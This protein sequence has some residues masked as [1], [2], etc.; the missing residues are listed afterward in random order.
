M[1]VGWP[2][3]EAADR[4]SGPPHAF[5]ARANRTLP[6]RCNL[7]LAYHC[8]LA[9]FA[10]LLLLDGS[11]DANGG[12]S[13][14]GASGSGTRQGSSSSVTQRPPH[15][16]ATLGEVI[17]S[18]PGG[19]ALAR[20]AAATWPPTYAHAD[21]DTFIELV[22]VGCKGWE[23]QAAFSPPLTIDQVNYL[24]RKHRLQGV[25]VAA[26][27][28]ALPCFE[29]L[30]EAWQHDS[31]AFVQRMAEAHGVNA[32]TLRRHCTAIGFELG[33]PATDPEVLD[34]LA[35]LRQQ[36]WCASLGVTFADARLRSLGIHARPDVIRRCLKTIDPLGAVA[37]AK[38]LAKTKYR[39]SVPG[40][41]SLYHMDAHE[42][43][44]KLW[45][46]WLHLMVDGYSRRILY[47]GARDNK[48]ARTVQSCFLTFCEAPCELTGAPHRWSSRVRMDKGRE[49]VLVALSQVERMGVGRGSVLTGRSIQNMRAEYVWVFVRKHVSG[50]FRGL[51]F[52]MMRR[53]ILDISD[54]YDLWALHVVFLSLVQQACDDFVV[55]WNSHR[56]AGAPVDAGFGGGIPD[57]MWQHAVASETVRSDDATFQQLGDQEYGV[58]DPTMTC[59]GEGM[60]LS[61]AQRHTADR[62][63]HWPALQELRAEY[64][65]E[66]PF[67]GADSSVADYL[68]YRSVS[69][70]LELAALAFPS[71]SDDML[72]NWPAFH[73]SQAAST[74]EWSSRVGLRAQLSLLAHKRY[75][76]GD[77]V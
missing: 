32:S 52:G 27:H 66:E 44:A 8:L 19:P 51:F 1:V 76:R 72:V 28:E 62:L 49:N 61:F 41:R 12:G 5:E 60:E 33:P 37:R 6:H 50:P 24:K 36:I 53:C 64:F 35:Y 4:A 30:D 34:G 29:Q 38:Q 22:R 55:M 47:L 3:S 46:I 70:E 71:P 75:Q 54:P 10:C 59:D 74:D 14:D 45:G 17:P 9:C 15:E 7:L 25:A 21:E 42:K 65:L 63:A 77:A 57:Q 48:F 43:L 67:T 73:E 31:Y 56:I 20:A 18:M 58:D 40:P 69:S 39:Y 68:R 11:G 16:E 23:L 26:R 2:G 13:S